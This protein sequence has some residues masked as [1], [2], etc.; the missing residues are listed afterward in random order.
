[1]SYPR[2]DPG[3]CKICGA[4]HT[5][6]TGPAATAVAVQLLPARDALMLAGE[7]NARAVRGPT[8]EGPTHTES[9]PFTTATYRRKRK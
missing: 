9:A 7:T 3:P 4:P 2:C 8:P 1:M 6:C 5:T